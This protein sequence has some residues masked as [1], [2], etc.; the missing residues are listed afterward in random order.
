M[1][2]I[3]AIIRPKQNVVGQDFK[4]KFY[5][6][7]LLD[8]KNDRHGKSAKYLPAFQLKFD[9]EPRDE[10]LSYV[11]TL[12]GGDHGGIKGERALVIPWKDG[13]RSSLSNYTLYCI[14]VCMRDKLNSSFVDK[15]QNSPGFYSLD[16]LISSLNSSSSLVFPQPTK[17]F[18]ANI[19]QWLKEKHSKA[20]VLDL[21]FRSR[22]DFRVKM[23]VSNPVFLPITM[24]LTSTGVQSTMRS[25]FPDEIR[26]AA[27]DS[28]AKMMAVEK[29]AK[30]VMNPLFASG[31]TVAKGG[32]R[33]MLDPPADYYM[34]G[35]ISRK[36]SLTST[37]GPDHYT[38]EERERYPL[39]L[40]AAK[41]DL[42]KVQDYLSYNFSYLEPD[43][44]GWMPIHI[45]ALHGHQDIVHAL[46]MAGCSPNVTNADERT[47]LHLAAKAGSLDVV[48][49]LLSHPEID[50]NVVDRKG[51]TAVDMC[52]QKLSWEHI[53][54][55]NIIQ[56]R[57]KQPK[58]IQVSLENY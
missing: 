22:A 20:D 14:P 49:V 55:G 26:I 50:T 35:T 11:Y 44:Y 58:Q 28:L 15:T 27:N 46:L 40:Y 9:K 54:I 53:K 45:A 12:T 16:T 52:E 43:Y 31:L 6:I 36:S 42:L 21:I 34:S 8:Y 29:C 19:E 23:N 48:N 51:Q 18:V 4:P 38:V 10:I 32:R 37:I 1:E 30:V 25:E 5:D 17:S 33:Q 7:L 3:L 57:A 47:P 2:A 41:G 13:H 39:H 56:Q 24:G